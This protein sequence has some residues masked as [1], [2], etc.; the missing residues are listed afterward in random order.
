MHVDDI[1]QRN[2]R[3]PGAEPA[4]A[5]S[6]MESFQRVLDDLDAARAELRGTAPLP[7]APLAD[8]PPPRRTVEPLWARDATHP[9][10][11]RTAGPPRRARWVGACGVG[12]VGGLL[13]VSSMLSHGALAPGDAGPSGQR[14]RPP[15]EDVNG[16]R[17]DP[18]TQGREAPRRT[19]R[20]PRLHPGGGSH[21]HYHIEV[22]A[23]AARFQDPA[24]PSR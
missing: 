20:L 16:S 19:Y 4:S 12:A 10:D 24:A 22:Q 15:H 5:Q 23:V 11:L 18:G 3:L 7:D 17:A 14:A 8:V 1:P 2:P 21:G 9:E 13:V 6:I